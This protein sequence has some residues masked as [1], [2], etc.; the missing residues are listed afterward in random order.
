M[1][2]KEIFVN[3][4]DEIAPFKQVRIKTRTEPWMSSEILALISERDKALFNANKSKSN[5]LLRQEYNMLR[6]KVQREVKK[7]KSN[8]SK[9]KIE[10][11][12]NDPKKL[13][14]QFKSLG[15]SSKS[16][17]NSK[18]VLNNDDNI[19]FEPKKIAQN[20]DDYF[21]F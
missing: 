21:F 14:K 1:R 2:F 11:H 15:Y 19:C 16:K 9:D 10:E 18:I 20:M 13:W 5:K 3:I 12:K 4:L 6:N 17:V 8:Y 7:S